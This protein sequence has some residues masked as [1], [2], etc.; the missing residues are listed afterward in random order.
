MSWVT[1][2]R[3]SRT[4]LKS[5]YSSNI[6]GRNFRNFFTLI[7]KHADDTT[8]AFL[9]AGRSVKNIR[10]RFEY[11]CVNA[12]EDEL[13][14]EWIGSNLKCECG[15]WLVVRSLAN[16]LVTSLWIGTN[17][18]A[19]VTIKWTW[20]IV[21]HEVKHL[22]DNH[23]TAITTS[24]EE[25]ITFKHA[26]TKGSFKLDFS[27]CF[28]TLAEILVHQC[29]IGLN[30]FFYEHRTS[31]LSFFNHISWNFANGKFVIS[32]ILV[33][34]SLHVDEINHAANVFFKTNW[35]VDC[36]SV[37]RKTLVN[38]IERFVE[39]TTDLVNLVYETNTWNAILGSLAPHSFRLSF[40]AHLAIEY[41]DGTIE[42]TK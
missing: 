32:I 24:N 18:L 34:V 13:A 38:R 25:E 3:T 37:L 2:S 4:F 39:I 26:L 9:V 15:K 5:N 10:T 19:L 31:V 7:S 36:H 23:A 6:A 20:E 12:D 14:N 28:F 1:K 11:A 8:N 33:G 40:N 35:E 29:F 21:G 27:N 22:L 16:D 41:H 17:S 42:H 30:S